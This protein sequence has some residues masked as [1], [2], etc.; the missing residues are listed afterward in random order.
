MAKSLKIL[1]IE[2]LEDEKVLRKKSV[3][4]SVEQ[5]KDPKFHIF[6]E[7]L[8]FTA[9]HSKE[10]VGYRAGGIAAIQVGEPLN[11]FYSLNYDTDEFEL[12]IN[13]KIDFLKPALYVAEEACLSVPNTAGQVARFNKI[14]I[15][16][17]DL[18]GNILKRNYSGWNSRSI[19]HE[20]DHTQG[21][22][23]IDKL[24]D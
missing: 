17:M 4:V 1:T 21:V 11:V 14:R 24:T 15:T 6:L 23:F 10:Q 5:L 7:D 12:F 20:Y 22:L 2:N 19:Q 3:D 8:L 13:P 16:F 18:E 9:K